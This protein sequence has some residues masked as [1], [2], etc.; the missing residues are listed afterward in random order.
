MR[1]DIFAIIPVKP[2]AECK[3]RLSPLLS[4]A[5]R[6]GLGRD[7]FKRSLAI[8]GEVVGPQNV[9]VVSRDHAALE[10]AGEVGSHPIAEQG[11]LN[12]NQA[13]A[14]AAQQLVARGASN[15]LVVPID[16]PLLTARSLQ[17]FIVDVLR[18]EPTMALAPD[19]RND[20]TNILYLEPPIIDAFRFGPSSFTAHQAVAASRGVP[21]IVHR[22]ADLA[23]DLDTPVDFEA[24]QQDS[25]LQLERW[26]DF[27]QRDPNVADV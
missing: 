14:Q 22:S 8:V 13:L 2:F 18:D 3:S 7:L 20:G 25:R 15:L 16:L 4:K 6:A 1:P 11:T 10:I 9:A 21:V 24:W 23:L 26:A 17:A 19:R 27:Y 5:Q 12:M